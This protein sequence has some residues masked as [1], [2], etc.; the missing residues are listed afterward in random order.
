[1]RSSKAKSFLVLVTGCW[2]RQCCV[3]IDRRRRMPYRRSNR[4]HHQK[5][6]LQCQPRSRLQMWWTTW[7]FGEFPVRKIFWNCASE[8]LPSDVLFASHG[9][10]ILSDLGENEI[11]A[12]YLSL[13]NLL[14]FMVSVLTLIWCSKN[15]FNFIT[16]GLE[17][18]FFEVWSWGMFLPLGLEIIL[19]SH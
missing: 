5:D 17:V 2:D 16:K 12:D 15:E 1:M 7:I 10:I 4:F 13:L 6:S 18:D 8:V 11:F 14:Q 3:N 19:M 9:F